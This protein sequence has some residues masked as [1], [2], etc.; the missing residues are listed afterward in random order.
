MDHKTFGRWIAA[1]FRSLIMP[2]VLFVSAV[3][4]VVWLGSYVFERVTGVPTLPESMAPPRMT[5]RQ[6]IAED[7]IACGVKN[8]LVD[9]KAAQ[10]KSKVIEDKIIKTLLNH[11][12]FYKKSL[13]NMLY[14]MDTLRPPGKAREGVPRRQEWY[15]SVEF[16]FEGKRIRALTARMRDLEK[17]GYGHQLMPDWHASHYFRPDRKRTMGNQTDAEKKALKNTLLEVGTEDGFTFLRPPQPK[18]P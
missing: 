2:L 7:E 18:C 8:V 10:N 13:C 3:G 9:M 17:E 14:D 5:D 6:R 11:K 4:F 15:M 12:C 1:P 16:V